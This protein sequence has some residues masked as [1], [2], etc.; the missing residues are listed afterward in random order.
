MSPVPYVM[1]VPPVGVGLWGRQYDVTRDGS[2]VCVLDREQAEP[3]ARIDIIL[4]WT[5]RSGTEIPVERSRC[6]D[7]GRMKRSGFVSFDVRRSVSA[8]VGIRIV[9]ER[10]QITP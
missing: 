10:C 2:R 9:S 3:E 4:G 1:G 7:D 8:D 6:R 5:A